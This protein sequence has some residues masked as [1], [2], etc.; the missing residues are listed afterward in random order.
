VR[1]HVAPALLGACQFTNRTRVLGRLYI[2]AFAAAPQLAEDVKSGHRYCAA[3]TAAL[4]GSG[5]SE[6]GGDLSQEERVRW[7]MMACSWL[8]EDLAAWARNWDSGIVADRDLVRRTLTGWL[9]DPDFAGVREPGALNRLSVEE[10]D[11]WLALWKQSHALIERVT[12]P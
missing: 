8:A 1:H 10:R 4:A 3:C 9:I 12:S 6:N 2:D 5:H 11:E 7:R